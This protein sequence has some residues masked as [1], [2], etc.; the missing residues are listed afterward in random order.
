MSVLDLRPLRHCLRA[1]MASQAPT[2]RHDHKGPSGMVGEPI[3][4]ATEHSP[5]ETAVTVRPNDDQIRVFSVCQFHKPA[6]ARLGFEQNAVVPDVR[7]AEPFGPRSAQVMFE[8]ASPRSH[9]VEREVATELTVVGEYVGGHHFGVHVRRHHRCPLERSRRA[10][11]SVNTN[12]DPR[13]RRHGDLAHLVDCR[14]CDRRS[15]TSAQ[16]TTFQTAVK[17]SAFRFSYCR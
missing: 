13:E 6:C 5:R 4:Q 12:E 15:A 17:K 11:R 14:A 7:D 1:P 3:A 2:R 8:L 10:I 16:F 9:R